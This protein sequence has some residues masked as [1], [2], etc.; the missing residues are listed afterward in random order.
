METD[1]S[2]LA[3]FA[4]AT[5]TVQIVMVLLMAASFW[6]WAIIVQKI[7]LFRQVRRA[8]AAFDAMFW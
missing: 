6:S 1:F 4:R 5:F 8:S 2:M 7:L 3:L